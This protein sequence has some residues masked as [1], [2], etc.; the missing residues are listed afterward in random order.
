MKVV[1]ARERGRC[2]VQFGSEEN[3]IF[4]LLGLPLLSPVKA[5]AGELVGGSWRWRMMDEGKGEELAGGGR[6]L[7][8]RFRF[9]FLS[10]SSIFFFFFSS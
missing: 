7:I 4:S 1:E 3:F 5:L 8:V 6:W 10:L 2:A 9:F